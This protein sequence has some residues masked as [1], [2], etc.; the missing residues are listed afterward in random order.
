[1]LRLQLPWEQLEEAAEL[2]AAEQAAYFAADDIKEG[3]AA[4]REKRLPRFK[5]TAAVD[6]QIQRKSSSKLL[7]HEA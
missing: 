3:L 7:L 5:S 6:P 4:V 1:M 2:E